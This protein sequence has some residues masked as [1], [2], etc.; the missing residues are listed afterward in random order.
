MNKKF[1]SVISLLAL[2][3]SGCSLANNES[4]SGQTTSATTGTSS[5]S[6]P[7]SSSTSGGEQPEPFDTTT[8]IGL[9]G[10]ALN[11]YNSAVT[12]EYMEENSSLDGKTSITQKELLSI[13][14][15][16]L[17]DKMPE[18]KG[19]R[20]YQG[21][22]STSL[23]TRSLT[24]DELADFNFF[25]SYGLLSGTYNPDEAFNITMV[26]YALD[27]IHQ[28][29][30]T[31]QKDDFASTVM[32]DFLYNADPYDG[33]TQNDYVYDSTVVNST[34]MYTNMLNLCQEAK[35][36]S[37]YSSL[38]HLYNLYTGA[39]TFDFKAKTSQFND[40]MNYIQDNLVDYASIAS[41]ESY[42]MNKDYQCSFIRD[43]QVSGYYDDSDERFNFMWSIKSDV[44]NIYSTLYQDYYNN[45]TNKFDIDGFWSNYQYTF[46]A[47]S[48]MAGSYTDIDVSS[49]PSNFYQFLV[50][51][52]EIFDDC[53]YNAQSLFSERRV[54]YY[55][56]FNYL[57]STTVPSFESYLTSEGLTTTNVTYGDID[58]L[59]DCLLGR[60][61]ELAKTDAS[62]IPLYKSFAYVACFNRYFQVTAYAQNNGTLSKAG[63][64]NIASYPLTAYFQTTDNYAYDKEK[65]RN[66]FDKLIYSL[67]A[68][69][70]TNGWLS[71][72]GISALQEKADLVTASLFASYEGEDYNYQSFYSGLDF[73]SDIAHDYMLSVKAKTK[74][75]SDWASNEKSL[76]YAVTVFM[77]PFTANA[78]Y[79]SLTNS[80][81]ITMGYL[82]SIGFDLHPISDEELMATFGLVVG[83]EITHGFDSNGCYWDG[84]GQ[85]TSSSIF[86]AAD[87]SKFQSKQ[88]D[89]I[90]LYTLEVMPGYI[91]SGSITLSEDL[92]DIGGMSLVHRIAK[93][94]Y[95]SF[96]Y[97]EFYTQIAKH[98]M[99]KFSRSTY[100]TG[101]SG[102][103]H[104][105]GK[106]RCNPL[107]MNC[108]KFME[109]FDVKN[110]DGMY[111]DPSKQI[112]IW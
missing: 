73:T 74:M 100:A 2:V 27:R 54:E 40:D 80:I 70:T 21:D 60:F 85:Y 11:K 1:L 47:Y 37:N 59:F 31:S 8:I 44:F 29:F 88:S 55:D 83:H 45:G 14:R 51:M 72:D 32:S 61:I 68:N 76:A 34:N 107:L 41:V 36:N 43:P 6:N 105:A 111:R 90:D 81:T 93:D 5:P 92:A 20:K 75:Y 95:S 13:V 38:S 79:Y 26:K 25:K 96:N 12:V 104:A 58:F 33:A 48:T 17:K 18:V 23:Y 28:Y 69:A 10:Y 98:F 102:D 42:F 110:G 64:T 35:N 16:A 46:S 77:D 57:T 53:G 30:G 86:P 103:V 15:K 82:A 71:A 24:D 9:V 65:I 4:T 94:N 66:I 108:P 101:L 89:V 97:R 50:K 91:Q 109:V 99:A 49:I 22:F 84:H 7:S 62:L 52:N 39:E 63:F 87:L 19:A 56:A 78:F 112:I 3:V 106:A 67:K